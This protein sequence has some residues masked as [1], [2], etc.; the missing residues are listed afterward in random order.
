MSPGSLLAG[1]SGMNLS[2]E[3]DSRTAV[4]GGKKRYLKQGATKLFVDI[5]VTCY[6]AVK[7]PS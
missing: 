2:R 5:P 3:T 4:M 6:P 1:V 7:V